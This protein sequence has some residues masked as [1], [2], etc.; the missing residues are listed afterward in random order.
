MPLDRSIRFLTSL[1]GAST[2][3]VL[4][5][6]RIAAD[7]T[8]NPEHA[9]RPLF[10]SPIINRGFLVKHRTRSDET[11][12]FNS[13]RTVATKLILPFDHGD[14]RAGGR[15]VFIDQRGYEDALRSAGNYRPET[16]ERDMNVLR[17]LASVPS[18]DPFLVREHLRNNSV[19][20]APCYFAISPGD[21]ERM[22]RFVSQEMSKL[23]QLASDGGGEEQDTARMV[24][25]L[26]S[27]EVGDRLAPLRATLGLT[28][29]DFREGVFSWRGFLYYKWS[30]NRF[31]PDV[32]GVLRE[33]SRVYPM[34]A[35][36]A[37][38]KAYLTRARQDIIRMVRDSGQHVTRALTV[39]DESFADLVA[40]QSPKS[41]RDFL[42]SAP[43]MFLELGEK[44]AAISHIV[45]FWR[46]RFP[47]GALAQVD[48]EELSAIFQD[49][50]SG[51]AENPR[52][53]SA[54]NRPP[55][56]IEVLSAL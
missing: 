48:A 2:S 7:N 19:E 45:S 30:M 16:L 23:I 5:L 21:Q 33:I 35:V 8:D 11:Y 37:E 31:W 22:H 1:G 15:S 56:A 25:A 24:S 6:C 55:Q 13:P 41:F 26:L 17:L 39:Y 38:Q 46:Y 43:F 44:L 32:M 27:T 20:V 51:F 49:F 54:F 12:L 14:L 52:E 36:D 40:H 3:R 47:L 42:M 50:S 4:N 34:G 28:G 53:R 10:L 18:L 9:Q 29:G